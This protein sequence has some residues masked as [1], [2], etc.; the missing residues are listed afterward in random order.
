MNTY[1]FLYFGLAHFFYPVSWVS[2]TYIQ[3]TCHMRTHPKQ[4]Q[5]FV[6]SLQIIVPILGVCAQIYATQIYVPC[7]DRTRGI[8]AESQLLTHCVNH[9][10]IISSKPLTRRL[11]SHIFWPNVSRGWPTKYTSKLKYLQ[12]FSSSRLKG[13]ESKFK[14]PINQ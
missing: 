1:L 12:Y 13:R 11:I 7:R 9:H 14:R 4:E 6:Y 5:L 8:C 10:N 3:Y 2:F